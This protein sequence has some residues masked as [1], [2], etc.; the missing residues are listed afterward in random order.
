M[1]RLTDP[2]QAAP[3]MDYIGR[4][5]Q[6]EKDFRHVRD[7]VGLPRRR[8]GRLVAGDNVNYV[9]YLTPDLIDLVA[10]VYAE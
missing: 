5:E 1:T 8:L 10:D 3:M 2:D 4:F 9:G 6:L 7:T